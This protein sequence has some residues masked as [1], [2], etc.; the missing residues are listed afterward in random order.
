MWR[1]RGPTVR[2][3]PQWTAKIDWAISHNRPMKVPTERC[4]PAAG[5]LRLNLPRRPRPPGGHEIFHSSARD[6]T[7]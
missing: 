4:T 1:V 3:H 5:G 6:S 7:N 2:T